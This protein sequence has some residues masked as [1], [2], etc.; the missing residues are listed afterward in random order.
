[1][2]ATHVWLITAT[3]SGI[4]YE[5]AKAA[6]AA[7]HTVI[8]VYRDK[9]KSPLLVAELDKLGVHWLQLD[10]STD[11]VETRIQEAIA[12]FGHIDVLVNNAGYAVAGALED[13]R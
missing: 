1:M 10:I 9:S 13:I 2:T 7:G 6:H 8:A 11:D 12:M 4:G 5:L 3:T